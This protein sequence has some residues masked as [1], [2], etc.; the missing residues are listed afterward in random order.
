[1][2]DYTFSMQIIPPGEKNQEKRFSFP[3]S[4]KSHLNFQKQVEIYIW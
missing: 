4:E 1:M 3:W 2:Y